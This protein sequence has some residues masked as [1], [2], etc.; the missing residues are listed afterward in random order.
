MFDSNYCSRNSC[1][2]DEGDIPLLLVGRLIF[3]SGLMIHFLDFIS[4]RWDSSWGVWLCHWLK[5]VQRAPWWLCTRGWGVLLWFQLRAGA[6]QQWSTSQQLHCYISNPNQ[7]HNRKL[8]AQNSGCFFS[9]VATWGH[10]SQ[11]KMAPTAPGFH[12]GGALRATVESATFNA[13]LQPLGGWM[14]LYVG[15]I[16]S[17]NPSCNPKKIE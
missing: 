5:Q 1:G 16:R 4:G 2:R 6:A 15:R 3:Q 17:S 7:S 12:R 11:E 8:V 9:L 13:E 14:R 10:S